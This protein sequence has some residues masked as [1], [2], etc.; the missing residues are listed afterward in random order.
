VLELLADLA[1]FVWVV[2]SHWQAYMT[3]GIAAAALFAYERLKA[4]VVSARVIRVGIVT[5]LV[6]AFFLTWR[7][8]LNATRKAEETMLPLR[9]S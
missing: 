7:D 3:G 8:Q 2:L 1:K 6:V 5:F 9:S 4:K